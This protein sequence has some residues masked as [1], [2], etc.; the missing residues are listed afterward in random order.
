MMRQNSNSGKQADVCLILEGTYPY[1]SG[2]VASWT[3]EL[4]TRQEHLTFHIVAILPKDAKQKMVYTLPKNVLSVTN[5][6]LQNLPEN[7]SSSAKF[8]EVI[9][10][11]LRKPLTAITHHGGLKDFK[12]F[13]DLVSPYAKHLGAEALTDCEDTFN[14]ITDMYEESFNESSF[15]DYFWSWRALMG[16][17]YALLLAPLP[18]AKIYHT[19]STGYAGVMAARAKLETGKPVILTEHGIYTNERRIEIASADWLEETASKIL[20]IDKLRR[21]LRDF[22]INSFASYSRICYEACDRIVTLYEGNQR[23]QIL[24]GASPEKLMLISNGVDVDRF[25]AIVRKTKKYPVIALIGRVVPIKDIKN[26]IRACAVVRAQLPDL[27]AYVIGPTDEDQDYYLE[28]VVMVEHL[29]LQDTI[30]FTGKVV[31]DDYLG[32]IDV[33]VL[34]SISEAQPLAILEAGA[35]GI[36]T[37]ATDVGACRELLLGTLAEQPS[38]GAGGVISPLSNPAAIAEGILTLLTQGDVYRSCSDA[39]RARVNAYYHK[40][41]QHAAYRALYQSYL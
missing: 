34:T 2:G 26:F 11:K 19:L 20:T 9:R 16:G 37:V 14:L 24:D 13:V 39:I 18:N 23:T 7:G 8:A 40:N 15:L 22:W 29:G 31:V 27:K 12:E 35:C 41:S 33:M 1:V 32:S 6:H 21:N 30:E 25:N 38:L 17:L 28:C 5:V 10:R 3:H 36:P 4:I